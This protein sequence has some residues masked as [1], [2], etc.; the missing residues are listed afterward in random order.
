ML[1]CVAGIISDEKYWGLA[2]RA[3]D[4]DVIAPKGEALTWLESFRLLAVKLDID[5]VPGTIVEKTPS[6]EE[7]GR[8]ILNNVAHYITRHGKIVGTYKKE[9]LWWPEKDYLSPGSGNHVFETEWGR[10]GMLIC[11][12]PFFHRLMLY[13]NFTCAGWDLAWPEAFRRVSVNSRSSTLAWQIL[14]RGC[15]CV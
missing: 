1:L 15:S 6:K 4:E 3:F 5:I 10:V 7:G 8:P 9:N 13:S 14:T 2:Q 11:E 12:K